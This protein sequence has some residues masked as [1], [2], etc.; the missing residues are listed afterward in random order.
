VALGESA[1]GWIDVSVTVRHGMPNWPGDPPIYLER[2]KDIRRGDDA[3]VSH[4][5]MGVHTG[6]HMDAPLHFIHGA[7]GLDTMPLEAIIGEARVIEISHPSRITTEELRAHRLRP[8]ER[9][10]FRTSNSEL[11][12]SRDSF[13]EDFVSIALDAA[14]HLVESRVRTVGVDY[15]SVGS[16]L[17][18]DGPVVHRTLLEAGIWI[19]EGLDLSAVRA[20][21][22]EMVCLPVKM[23]ESD[24]APARAILRPLRGPGRSL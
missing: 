22:Y 9:V 14:A 3:N 10:L 6:T 19:I 4:V 23:H 5:A 16:Y 17:G 12:W 21:Y 20:G 11:C 24:G 2:A 7:D 8:G 15:L 18:D 13:M 1:S